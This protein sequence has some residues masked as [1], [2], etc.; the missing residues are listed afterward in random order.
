[1]SP[2]TPAP[3]EITRMLRRWKTGDREAL[4]ALTSLAYNDLRAI[5]AGYL[6]REDS[7]HTLQATG[8]VNDHLVSCFRYAELT[9]AGA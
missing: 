1:M 4:A 5:A 6:R 9:G 7:S 8:L 3:S 2:E